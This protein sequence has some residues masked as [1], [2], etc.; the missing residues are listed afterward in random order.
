MLKA[1]PLGLLILK[2]LMT[3]LVGNMIVVELIL[4]FVVVDFWFTKNITGRKMAGLR[5]SF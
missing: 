2:G 4:I 5:W 1:I 3:G